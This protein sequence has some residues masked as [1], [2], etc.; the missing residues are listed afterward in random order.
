MASTVFLLWFV[1][2]EDEENDNGL[3]IGV[4]Q[5]EFGA[6]SA[7]ERLRTKPGFADYPEGFQ[8]HSRELDHGSWTEG[9]V[10]ADA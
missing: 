2:K 3:L 1:T 5:T 8:I 6:T 4:Y 10:K 7:I 9:F